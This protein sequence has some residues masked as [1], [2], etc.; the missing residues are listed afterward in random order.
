VYWID[1]RPHF[2]ITVTSLIKG[3]HATLKSYLQYRNSDLRSVFN[4]LRLFWTV[5]YTSITIAIAQ[6]QFR[7]KHS[8]NP[9]LFSAIREYIYSYAL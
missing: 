2:S 5:Q 3:C 9:A 8:T 7:P 4:K 6:Q 1:Q